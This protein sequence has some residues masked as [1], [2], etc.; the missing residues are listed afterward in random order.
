[1][2]ETDNSLFI[3][4]NKERI[5]ILAVYI[6]DI[7]VIGNDQ[8]DTRNAKSIVK[9]TFKIKDLGKLRFFLGMEVA[10]SNK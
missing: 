8:Q 10:Y 9:K 2:S 5:T 4:K 1:M 3:K 7:I 6:D